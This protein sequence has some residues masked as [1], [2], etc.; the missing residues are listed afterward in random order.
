MGWKLMAETKTRDIPRRDIKVR[1]DSIDT[2]ARTF[3]VVMTTERA[4]TVF[5]W[6]RYDLIDEVILADG[7]TIEDEVPFMVDHSRS[8]ESTVGAARML[9]NEGV[10][11]IGSVRMLTDDEAADRAF[12][13]ISQK[14]IR[15]VSIGYQVD[16]A[17]DIPKGKSQ[18]VNGKEYTAG[19]RTLRI[20]TK[21]RIKELS[22]TPIGA[23]DAAKIRNQHGATPLNQGGNS[24]PTPLKDGAAVEGDAP[25]NEGN[26]P[27]APAT[28]KPD[29]KR[30]APEPTSQD[31]KDDLASKPTIDMAELQRKAIETERKRMKDIRDAA[32]DDVPAEVVTRAIDEGWT[33]ERA[34][35]TFLQAVRD[36]RRSV[37]ARDGAISDKDMARHA[38]TSALLSRS[39][40]NY[41]ANPMGG[42]RFADDDAKRKAQERAADKGDRLGCHSLADFCKE[43][44]RA[45]GREIPSGSVGD[46]FRAAV[47]TSTLNYVFSSNVETAFG[48]GYDRAGDTTSWCETGEVDNFKTQ[49]DATLRETTALTKH[50]R[51]GT[52]DTTTIGDEAETFR[53]ARY[54]Q[55]F[56]IDE[57]DIIDDSMNQ[58]SE[59][60]AEMG[61]QA[62]QLRPDLVYALLL[63]NPD[64]SDTGAVF[65]DTAVTTAGGHANLTTAVLGTA[66]LKAAITAMGKQKRG[67]NQLNLRPQYLII[68]QDLVWTAREL[69][70]SSGIVIAGTSDPVTERGNKNV[71]TG[72]GITI[73]ADNRIGAGGVTDPDSGTAYT[74]SATNFF[75]AA[76]MRTLKVVY[77]RGTGRRPTV[78]RFDLSQGQWGIGFDI[79]LDMGA[80]FRDWRGLHKS[81]GAG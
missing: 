44:L 4:V 39:G 50:K 70:E 27:Q 47:T 72:Q 49:T 16:E 64:M 21:T 36:S 23:D 11:T 66:G 17:T 28:P 31:I 33:L 12:R 78:R 58:L 61:Y 67:D 41:D 6:D 20:S 19:E 25:K 76:A 37:G 42:V 38:L 55:K 32:G 45:E 57:Q 5:D 9:R 29:A 26:E 60:P 62:A 46:L 24:M 8:V 75:L 80:Y 68:P 35:P 65:N 56:V 74:G 40:L 14:A 43:A 77:R 51:G 22:L 53:I 69:L 71:L 79:N 73:V 30:S 3:E 15:D 81:T 1:G 18:T 48:M 2:E 10:N 52:A 34:A 54:S 13:R 7:I 59:I 63:A